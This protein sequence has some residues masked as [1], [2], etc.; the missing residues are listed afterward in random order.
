MP[1]GNRVKK[2]LFALYAFASALP[3]AAAIAEPVK[4][5]LMSPAPPPALAAVSTGLAAALA[6]RGLVSDRDFTIELRSAEGKVERLPVLAKELVDA[7]VAV[8]VTSSYPA[9]RAASDAT[10]AIPIVSINAGEPVETGFAAT[11]AH[12][13]GNVTGL[14]DMSSELS[15]K[16]L[17]LLRLVVPG[18][19]RV[20]MLWNAEDLGMTGRYKAASAGAATMGIAVQAL[21][22]REPDD[23]NSAFAAMVREK[24]DGILMV[25]DILTLLNRKRVFEFADAHHL[26]AI[27]E[28]D[29]LTR[30]GGLM[31]YG[32]DGK[33]VLARVSDLIMRILKGA[34][35]ADLPFEQPTRFLFVVNRKTADSDGLT[36]PQS[37]LERADEV[38]E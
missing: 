15:A 18:M 37:L 3:P 13:G 38:I 27:Y 14:S 16:R 33:E 25:T 24:P 11:L 17:E 12:P 22:V 28:F 35:P 21:G 4:I 9:A 5:G 29:N 26:P 36:L 7:H 23:F 8:I 1:E 30:D 34:K 10:S 31:S 2:F 19:K 32:A 6:Q 20:A